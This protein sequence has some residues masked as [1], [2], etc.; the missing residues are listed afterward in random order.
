MQKEGLLDRLD[1]L[2]LE[3]KKLMIK[4]DVLRTQLRIEKETQLQEKW[5]T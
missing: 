3:A 5:Q 2:Y 1:E 4:L